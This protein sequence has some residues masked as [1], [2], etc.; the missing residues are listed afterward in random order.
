MGKLLV[1][2]LP[3]ASHPMSE[4]MSGNKATSVL[5]PSARPLIT[6][7]SLCGPPRMD[8]NLRRSFV[9]P[10]LAPLEARGLPIRSNR[11]ER[12][13]SSGGNPTLQNILTLPCLAIRMG[14]HAGSLAQDS[15]CHGSFNE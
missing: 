3:S 2:D 5:L 13:Q 6:R 8:S 9:P 15:R 12:N 14:W 11:D 1:A 10:D 4:S 7:I